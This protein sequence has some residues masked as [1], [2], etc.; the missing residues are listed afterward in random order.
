MKFYENE[1]RTVEVTVRD[2]EEED[3]NIDTATCHIENSSGDTVMA[4]ATAMVVGNVVKITVPTTVTDTK[5]IY[6][7]IWTLTKNSLIYKHKTIL[8]I[9]E[10]S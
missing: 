1:Y 8:N 3:F 2:M 5:G 10:L 7:I 6:F 4:E 9:E